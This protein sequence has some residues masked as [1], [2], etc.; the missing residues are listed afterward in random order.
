[1][2]KQPQSLLTFKN[3]LLFVMAVV[4]IYLLQC[5]GK[6]TPVTPV[7]KPSTEI[8]QAIVNVDSIK[9]AVSDSFTT[10]IK[11]QD[12]LLKFKDSK[13]DDLLAE[14]LNQ[15]NDFQDSLANKKIPDTCKPYQLKWLAQYNELAKTSTQKDNASKSLIASLREQGVTKDKYLA[16]E[17]KSFKDLRAIADTCVKGYQTLE[18]AVKKLQPKREINV[19]AKVLSEYTLPLNTIYGLELGY[20]NKKGFE[21]NVGYYSNNQ[22]SIGIKKTLFRF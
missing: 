5:N 12:R 2:Q 19:G 9:D 1:M 6:D 17:K 22:I 15:A 10:V 21:I 18:K 7:V 8:V 16:A 13:Y 4:L 14:Y 3:L 11:E 20:R